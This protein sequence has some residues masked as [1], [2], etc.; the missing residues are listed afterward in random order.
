MQI[1][2]L[3]AELCLDRPVVLELL[4]NPPP[5]LVMMSA[6]LPDHEPPPTITVT[7]VKTIETVVEKTTTP[8]SDTAEKVPVHVMQQRFS[9]QKRLKKAHLQTLEDVYRRTKRPTVSEVS[10]IFPA[11]FFMASEAIYCISCCHVN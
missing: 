2:S 11:L 6:A 4:R 9:S 5:N 1:K 7:E 8:K 3:A 10:I